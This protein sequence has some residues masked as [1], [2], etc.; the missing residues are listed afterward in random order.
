MGKPG[1]LQSMGLQRVGHDF[2]TEHHQQS[3]SLG[4]YHGLNYCRCVVNLE[5]KYYTFCPF[6]KL[7][8]PF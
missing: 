4:Q 2:A 7:F 1:L 6:S 3:L 8:W 5:T